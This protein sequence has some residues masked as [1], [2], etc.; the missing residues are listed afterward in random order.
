M[1]TRKTYLP[2]LAS[3]LS[4]VIVAG[5]AAAPKTTS[6]SSP[7]PT[8]KEAAA[9]Q[10]TGPWE[11]TDD[12]GNT[13]SL[14]Q[15][16][17]RIVAQSN[18]A[19]A[20][21]DLGIKVVGVFG[22]QRKADGSN[23]PEVGSVDLR[24]VTSVGEK[25]GELDLEK[26]AA[27]RPDLIVTTM[28]LPPDLWYIAPDVAP[29]VAA[30]APTIGINVAQQPISVPMKRFEALAQSLGADLDAPEIA[31]AR[32]RFEKA[33]ADLKT[34]IAEKPGLKVMFAA[35]SLETL[36]VAN[37]PYYADLL[38]FKELGLDVVVPEKPN[39]FTEALS[40]EQALRYPADLMLYDVR[41]HVVQP[42][43]LAEKIPTWSMQPAVKAGQ[44]APWHAVPAYSY[45]GFTGIIED[46]TATIRKVRADVVQ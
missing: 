1:A 27:L 25:W 40:W 39:Q 46:L 34:A 30:I 29:K 14:P 3:I 21:W 33:G 12:R 31:T 8:A 19:A 45:K 10:T 18:A 41:S 36:W 23:D 2:L 44:V 17:V 38:Y 37:P 32:Q 13:V 42:Q 5:C 11:F 15:R 22:P 16:P 7:T 26:L 24:A 4:L 20:L 28:W 6:P 35:G 43:Q 9:P